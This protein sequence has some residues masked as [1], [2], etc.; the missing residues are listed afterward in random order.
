MAKLYP[1]EVQLPNHIYKIKVIKESRVM[2]QPKGAK[3]HKV[4]KLCTTV[5]GAGACG[6]CGCVDTAKACRFCDARLC[7]K[8]CLKYHETCCNASRAC[9]LWKKG[10]PVHKTLFVWRLQEGLSLWC[11]LSKEAS[12]DAQ[13]RLWWG[14]KVMILCLMECRFNWLGFGLGFCGAIF[15]YIKGSIGDI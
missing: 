12:R 8:D 9:F 10:R 7:G 5:K 15:A 3:Q 14:N 11:G 6:N 13:E 1:R 2:S 4:M